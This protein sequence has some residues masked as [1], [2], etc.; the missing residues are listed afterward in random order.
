MNCKKSGPDVA[1]DDVAIIGTTSL[2]P[3]V[4]GLTDFHEQLREGYDGI[5]QPSAHRLRD[6]GGTPDTQYV[7]MGYLDRVDLFDHQFFGLSLREAELM[8]PHQR[9]VLQLAH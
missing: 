4:D 5:A 1:H 2:F 7:A 9:L 6:S 8:D 3:G